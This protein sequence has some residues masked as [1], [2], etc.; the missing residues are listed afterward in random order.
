MGNAGKDWT[1]LREHSMTELCTSSLQLFFVLTQ[2]LTV[3]VQAGLKL[4]G[5]GGPAASDCFSFFLFGVGGRRSARDGTQGLCHARKAFLHWATSLAQVY[6]WIWIWK[7]PFYYNERK[8]GWAPLGLEIALHNGGPE[9][10]RTCFAHITTQTPWANHSVAYRIWSS[11]ISY[12]Q[13]QMWLLPNF[14]LLSFSHH[15]TQPHF[16]FQH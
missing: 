3:V 16:G 2:G 15:K 4:V 14:L 6:L 1:R 11:R 5:S 10:M 13:G 8:N 12:S 9:P 7:Y